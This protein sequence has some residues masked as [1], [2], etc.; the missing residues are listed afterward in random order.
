M[1]VN[2]LRTRQRGGAGLASRDV[3][4]R[5]AASSVEPSV[6]E[7]RGRVNVCEE[8]E[9]ALAQPEVT[10]PWMEPALWSALQRHA[11]LL[12]HLRL[13]HY[14]EIIP[15][16][17]YLVPWSVRSRVGHRSKGTAAR[18]LADETTDDAG[19][20]RA[21]PALMALFALASASV[22]APV[23]DAPEKAVS[24][25]SASSRNHGRATGRG[26][27]L[28]GMLCSFQDELSYEP[29]CTDFGPYNLAQTMRFVNRIES[30]VNELRLW[31]ERTDGVLVSRDPDNVDTMSPRRQ[32]TSVSDRGRSTRESALGRADPAP[33]TTPSQPIG[34]ILC[35]DDPEAVTN[36]A[37]LVGAYRVL[38]HGDTP[39]QAYA[40]L[41]RLQDLF[42]HF[43]DASAGPESPFPL[44]VF[45][46]ISA[47]HRAAQK[48]HFF[49]PDTF[50]IDAY[51]YLECVQHGDLNWI[52]PG[53]LLAFAGPSSS[54]ESSDGVPVCHPEH[55]VPLFQRF[56][57][58]AVVR[59]NRRRYDARIFRQAGF[60]HFDLYFADGGCPDLGIVQRFLDI[61]RHEPGAIAVHCKAGLGRTGTL[62]CCALMHQHGFTATEAIA[63]CRL[64]RP[65]SVIGAQQHFLVQIEP[66]LQ[67]IMSDSPTAPPRPMSRLG[68]SPSWEK[69]PH[70]RNVSETKEPS[71][72]AHALETPVRQRRNSARLVSTAK[73]PAMDQCMAVTSPPETPQKRSRRLV[74]NDSEEMSEISQV[75]N[76]VRLVASRRA[77]LPLETWIPPPVNGHRI[78]ICTGRG[79]RTRSQSASAAST[80]ASMP[81]SWRDDAV[82]TVRSRSQTTEGFR[83]GGAC[84]RRLSDDAL[85][86]P[87]RSDHDPSIPADV[88]RDMVLACSRNRKDRSMEMETPILRPI[89]RL[90]RYRRRATSTSVSEIASP[91]S[92]ACV[93][94]SFSIDPG[95]V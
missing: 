76:D 11:D 58:T 6:E 62:M 7:T 40:K 18:L 75:L 38:Y 8:L 28:A 54:L 12:S 57:V 22:Q 47:W 87:L 83:R 69:I 70:Q 82:R 10:L 52:V 21:P 24:S 37:V 73:T 5:T 92:A 78:V 94:C 46:C 77:L 31:R 20:L 36:A 71:I 64:S 95:V 86:N 23:H 13:E 90:S 33:Q 91:A 89:P 72:D 43:R 14:A 27:Q 9:D 41:Q 49:C 3:I 1:F 60:R 68:A 2:L 67:G 93:S 55:Y 16:T 80:G 51:E 74:E 59:L 85:S 81:E 19:R 29:F 61:C 15:D 48:C 45:D 39:E 17:L 63:W 34:L 42:I 4:E 25:R 26:R 88:E 50:D 44:S 65:G 30:V 53:K 35:T 32:Q 66:R 56:G 84:R 79:V